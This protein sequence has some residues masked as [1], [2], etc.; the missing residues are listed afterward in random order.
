[1]QMKYTCKIK[2]YN[3]VNPDQTALIWIHN[4]CSL[5]LKVHKQNREQMKIAMNSRK[6]VKTSL[7]YLLGAVMEIPHLGTKNTQWFF[8]HVRSILVLT[9]AS[10]LTQ[11]WI[12]SA[13]VYIVLT[14]S[15]RKSKSAV[16]WKPRLVRRTST[17]IGAWLAYAVIHSLTVYSYNRKYIWTSSPDFGTCRICAKVP[18]KHPCWCIQRA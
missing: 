15:S 14:R 13:L 6:M 10:I 1:M 8:L 4:V 12:D 3:S 16:T 7:I 11:V 9:G 2:I 17:T 5:V 18:F